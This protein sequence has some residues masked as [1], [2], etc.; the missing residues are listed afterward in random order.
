MQAVLNGRVV[1]RGEQLTLGLELVDARTGNQIW[2][3]QYNRKADDLLALQ[4][5]IARDVSN[6][7]RMKFSGADEQRLAKTYTANAEAY[8]LYL[9]G[10]FYWNKRT[11]KDLQKAIEYFQQAVTV[12]QAYALGY[13]G[14]ADAYA[15]L[16]NYRGAP[17][18]EAMPKA[19]DAALKALSLDNKLAEAY[20]ALGLIL[21]DYDY[22]FAGSEREYK[23]AIE[24]NPNYASAHHYYGNLLSRLGRHE[25]SFAEFRRAL[26][27]DPLS[28][29]INR[30]YADGLFRAR[31]Y[32]ESIAQLK[33]TLELDA[34]F[35]SA[36][37]SLSNAY[38]LRG[39]YVESVEAFA[40]HQELNGEHENA[41]IIRQ[42]FARGGWQ[43]FLRMMTEGHRLPNLEFYTIATFHAAL[44]END[45]AF[46]ELNK[47]Y[48]RRENTLVWLIV[49]PRLDPLRL[50]PRFKDLLR[51]VGF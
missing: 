7:L 35:V 29:I 3:E 15:L 19:K 24:L 8:K 49:D 40:K 42:S 2:G 34:N 38:Q 36:Y 51:R 30:M 26:E 31:K 27:I 33:K 11:V 9:Q 22:D 45:K 37:S 17:P 10:R 39:N 46:A 25:E 23:L 18:R 28:L 32:D 48:E 4:G 47:S 44:G 50:D 12:D 13:A 41:A 1:Q 5:E 14:L 21:S 16:S 6:K 20:T 43:R